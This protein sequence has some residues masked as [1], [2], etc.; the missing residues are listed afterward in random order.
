M[1]AGHRTSYKL[2]P[3]HMPNLIDPG[4]TGVLIREAQA[5]NDV[6]KNLSKMKLDD[7]DAIVTGAKDN[8]VRVWSLSFDLLGNINGKTDMDDPKWNVPSA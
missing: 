6:I 4:M 1:T 2:K 3:P 7:F 8:R 5:H